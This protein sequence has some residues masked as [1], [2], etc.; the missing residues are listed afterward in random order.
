M[1]KIADALRARS[2]RE[3]VIIA[4]GFLLLIVVIGYVLLSS[5]GDEDPE[6]LGP[7]PT[8]TRRATPRPTTTAA[9]GSTVGSTLGEG[10]DPFEPALNGNG[11]PTPG[12]TPSAG[13]PTGP[14]PTGEQR[15]VTLIDIFEEDDELQATVQVGGTD[16]TVGEGD[17]FATN[18]RVA[19]LNDRCGTFLFGDERFTL[20]IGQEVLK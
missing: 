14:N 19:D 15:R 12:A 2:R 9:T 4:A 20:C 10:K 1:S 3:Q 13:G 17:V 6:S 18:F 8:T 5:G 11:G 16:Y 7:V